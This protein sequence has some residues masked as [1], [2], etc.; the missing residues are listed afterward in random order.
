VIKRKPVEHKNGEQGKELVYRTQWQTAID[1]ENGIVD[2][3]KCQ[4]A[5]R[6]GEPCGARKTLNP[7]DEA[8]NPAGGVGDF[9]TLL[10]GLF[11][12]LDH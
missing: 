4:G 12:T 6:V 2:E 8:I 1:P 7:N 11:N 5:K 9:H 3:D 10:Q